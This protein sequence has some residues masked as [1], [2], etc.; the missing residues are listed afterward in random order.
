MSAEA[1]QVL[2]S[3]AEELDR[4]GH[5]LQ[6]CKCYEAIC[7]SYT[8]PTNE[9]RARLRLAQNLLR[10]THCVFEAK[11]HLERAHFLVKGRM[12]IPVA[13]RIQESNLIIMKNAYT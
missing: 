10:H 3:L 8:T 11:N 7:Q 12:S 13:E 2:F 6:A 1:T 5:P 9:T 4:E